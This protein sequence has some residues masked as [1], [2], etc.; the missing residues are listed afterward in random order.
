MDGFHPSIYCLF[1][2]GWQAWYSWDKHKA[3]TAS[4]EPNYKLNYSFPLL[5]YSSTRPTSAEIK[6]NINMLQNKTVT[7]QNGI[8][9]SV[10]CYN[11]NTMPQKQHTN[12]TKHC[13]WDHLRG[14]CARIFNTSI[15]K[16]I[17]WNARR[18]STANR[19]NTT[20]TY[21]ALWY[22]IFP[23]QWRGT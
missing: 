16:S 17:L 20:L 23:Q 19:M 8:Q 13:N 9:S 14:Q 5:I 10:N 7:H 15:C 22:S 18:L 3:V 1:V 2:S 6:M 11:K 21:Q 4:V 12:E